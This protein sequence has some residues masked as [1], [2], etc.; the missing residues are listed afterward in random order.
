MVTATDPSSTSSIAPS[1]HG[2][3]PLYRT[4]TTVIETPDHG[5]R[6]CL[7]GQLDSAPPICGDVPVVGL[8]WSTVSGKQTV[9]GV[10]WIE[11]ALVTGT[12]DGTA[13]TV[14]EPPRK[15]TDVERAAQYPGDAPA[16]CPEPASGWAAQGAGFA[17]GSDYNEYVSKLSPLA[18]SQ[19][20][21]GGM[22]LAFIGDPSTFRIDQHPEKVIPVVLFTGDV[23][24]H[25]AELRAVWPGALCV[26][27]AAMTAD[28]MQAIADKVTLD[29]Q[30][31]DS[32]D[33]VMRAGANV[34]YSRGSVVVYVPAVTAS[35]QAAFDAR[36]GAGVVT[37]R[38]ALLPVTNN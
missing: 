8:D 28:K 30:G 38:G 27:T 9:G 31:P 5:P 37:L 26:A 23:A 6:L 35:L 34:D 36:Y 7:G 25:E 21:F 20:D 16:P 33:P 32:L 13:L 3:A 10:T 15:A 11:Q 17:P 24:R 29:E 14:T 4:V 2:F 12:F 18:T 19:P 22:W 1:D